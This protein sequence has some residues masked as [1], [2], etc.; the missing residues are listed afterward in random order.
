ML[1]GLANVSS[2]SAAVT[3]EEAVNEVK[4]EGRVLSAKTVNGRHEI[5]VLTPSGTV[6]TINRNAHT[7]AE[8]H[9]P[10][11]PDY[12]NRTAHSMRDRKT[13]Q[14]MPNRFN[15]RQNTRGGDGRRNNRQMDL[16]P[17]MT[18]RKSNTQSNKGN[19]KNKDK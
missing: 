2:V 9:Q 3:L 19:N 7:A 11:R 5:K 12:Q 4:S 13:N 14:A 18:D 1:A 15:S 6:K 10:N 17:M 16:Q 8:E